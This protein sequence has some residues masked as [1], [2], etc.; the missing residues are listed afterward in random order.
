[1]TEPVDTAHNGPGHGAIALDKARERLDRLEHGRRTGFLVA[2]GRRFTEV[3]GSD[4]AG[5]LAIELF[6]TVIPLI[7]IGF[8]YFTGFA[9]NASIGDMFI[10]TMNVGGDLAQTVHDTFAQSSGLRSVW[11]VTE[12]AGYLIWGIP[13]ALTV[14]RLFAKA[15]RREPFPVVIRI[16]RGSCWFLIYLATIFAGQRIARLGSGNVERTFT[17]LLSTIPSFFFWALTPVILVRNGGKGWRYL[18][19]V[20]L[21]GLVVDSLALRLVG[22]VVFPILLSGWTGFGPIGVA[23]ALMTWCG[24]MGVSWVITA[25]VGAVLWERRA[26]IPTVLGAQANPDRTETTAQPATGA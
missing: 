8:A 24:V 1:M 9:E 20:G 18:L 5:L 11:S 10:R 4:Q 2:V 19:E 14:A 16:I 23:M 15:W 25:C 3:G 22:R 12:M 7:V 17:F 21:V 6:S 13:M 26:P